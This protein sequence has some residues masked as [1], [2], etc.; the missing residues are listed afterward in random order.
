MLTSFVS[1]W[2][3]WSVLMMRSRRA[4]KAQIMAARKFFKYVHYKFCIFTW[5]NDILSILLFLKDHSIFEN[6]NQGDISDIADNQVCFLSLDI[7]I[8]HL[9]TLLRINILIFLKVD[10]ENSPVRNLINV[11]AGFSSSKSIIPSV[12]CSTYLN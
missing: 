10:C 12:C 4:M 2:N 8:V 6:S 5:F 11:D 3:E 1:T 7:Y 9:G